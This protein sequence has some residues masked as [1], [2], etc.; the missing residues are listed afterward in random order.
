M[1]GRRL[2]A[3]LVVVLSG[4]LADAPVAPARQ[5][6]GARGQALI[7]LRRGLVITK[8]VRVAPKVYRLAATESLDSA[9]I[10]VRGDDVTVDFAGATLEGSDR[11]ADPDAA[12]G[13][14]IRV[15]GGRNVVVR[16]VNVRG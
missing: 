7:E 3:V 8:S 15:D 6:F 11:S 10:V 5:L 4:S 2:I 9:I 13:V 12:I 14:A 16:N 1:V